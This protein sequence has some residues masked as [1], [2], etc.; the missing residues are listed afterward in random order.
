[1][2][3][4]PWSTSGE[5]PSLEPAAAGVACPVGVE[6]PSAIVILKGMEASEVRGVLEGEWPEVAAMLVE[7]DADP[8][9]GGPLLP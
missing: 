6:A 3:G 7:H 9:S 4:R 2:T 8:V 5:A 1:M